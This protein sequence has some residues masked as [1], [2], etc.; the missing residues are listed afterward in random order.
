MKYECNVDQ[1][2]SGAKAG[3]QAIHL[4]KSVFDKNSK[5][6]WGFCWEIQ[7]MFS[8]KLTDLLCFGM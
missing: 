4:M 6:G 3:A 5:N 1:V 2:S 7:T 8:I